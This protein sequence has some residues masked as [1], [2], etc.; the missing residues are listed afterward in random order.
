MVFRRRVPADIRARVGRSEIIRTLRT[1]SLVK[2]RQGSRWLWTETE[3]LFVMLRENPSVTRDHVEKMLSLLD[4]DCRWTDEVT[5]ARNGGFF[6]HHG[7][8]PRNAD[9]IVLETIANDYR[10]ALARNDVSEVRDSVQRYAARL[11]LDVTPDSLDE[12]ILGRAILKAY[13]NSCEMSAARAKEMRQILEPEDFAAPF[14]CVSS[15]P[16]EHVV[17]DEQ[18]STRSVATVLE[19]EAAGDEATATNEEQN[20][21]DQPSARQPL[22]LLW[23]GFTKDQTQKKKWGRS[24]A[25]QSFGTMRLWRQIIGERR[26]LR[27]GAADAEAF[28]RLLLSLPGDY[29]KSKAWRDM[30][31]REIAEASKSMGLKPISLTTCNRHFSVMTAFFDWAVRNELIE[32]TDN[33]FMGLWIEPDEDL[34][35]MEGGSAKRKMWE[36]EQLRALFCSPLFLGCQSEARRHKPGNHVIRDPLYWVIL[37]AAFSGVRREE[38]CQLRVRHIQKETDPDTGED[39]WYIDLKAPGLQLKGKESR[40]WVPLHDDFR[41]LGFLEGRVQD[42][43]PD[44]LLFSE[45]RASAADGAYGDKLGQKFTRYRQL[46]GLYEALLDIHSFRHTVSTLLIRAG[47]PQAHAE[48]LIGHKSDARRTTFAIYD[49]GATIA[50]MKQAIDKLVLPIDVPRLVAAATASA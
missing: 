11:G 39:I 33:P 24:Y 41:A 14:D 5:L 7:A 44:E 23:T 32:K 9:E 16:S 8:V 2:A 36:I 26:P 17:R 42:R 12:R 10:T 21:S 1:G 47:V 22:E 46:I 29:S 38:A 48:E 18:F 40:R 4:A 13:A 28:S 30:G 45:L 20:D 27:I 6:D 43:P 49:K 3:R 19:S 31:L 34:D 15:L 35:P 25:R 50:I 37:L